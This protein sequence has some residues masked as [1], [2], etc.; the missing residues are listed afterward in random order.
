MVQ[1]AGKA[2]ASKPLLGISSVLPDYTSPFKT[3]HKHHCVIKCLQD[4]QALCFMVGNGSF[5]ALRV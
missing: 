5:K 4:L 3:F 2:Y 1:H